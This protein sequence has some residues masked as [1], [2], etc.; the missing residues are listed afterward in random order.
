MV[1]MIKGAGQ[2]HSQTPI[3]TVTLNPALDLGT[4]VERVSPDIKLRCAAP[5]THPGGGGINVSRAIARLGGES[6]AAVSLGGPSGDSLAALLSA[7]GV[8]SLPLPSPGETRLSLAVRETLTGQ[9]FRFMLPGPSWAAVDTN[10]AVAAVAAAARPAG[11]VVLSGSNPPGVPDDIAARLAVALRGTGCHLYVDTSGPAL[12]ALAAAPAGLALLRMDG[13]EA[14][15]LAGAPLPTRKASAAFAADLVA[16]GVAEEVLVAR[17]GDGNIVATAD[18]IWHA[19]A[20][21]IR[22]ISAVGAGDSFLGAYTLSRARGDSAE[23][24]LGWGA[25][26]ASA[27][28]MTPATEL[29]R[30]DD[31]H[32]LH[33]MGS[34]TRMQL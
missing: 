32:R 6:C 17:G 1:G 33:E 31:L 18:G 15:D 16:R 5:A 28:C 19:E 25:A 30:L 10:A 22:V 29:F 34:V 23:G 21:R 3:L 26:A 9:Q 4:E 12:H 13:A 24:A 7:E 14:E 20:L 27:A 8:E 11:W 2:G